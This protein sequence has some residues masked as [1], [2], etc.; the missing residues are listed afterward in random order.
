MSKLWQ[1][2]L[3]IPT[4]VRLTA[5]AP[6]DPHTAWDRYWTGIRATGRA[7][8]VLW[9]SGS[10]LEHEQY[11]GI[12]LDG[13]DPELPVIDVGC[14]NGTHTR[15]LAGLFPRV[16]GLDVSEGAIARAEEEAKDVPNADFLVL[17]AAGDG[18]GELLLERLG[19]A[20]VFVRGVFHVLKSDRQAA[21]ATNLRTVT[22][23]RGRV[24]LAETNF[25]GSSL[26]YLTELGATHH[27]VPRPL[28]R[29]LEHLPR[30]G[31]F[32]ATERQT[33]FPA[34]EWQVLAD[35]PTTIEVVPMKSTDLQQIPGYYAL[36]AGV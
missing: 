29:A 33:I 24:F 4:V 11:A 25:P 26:D 22:A 28:K 14:G 2:L 20:N 32:G 36:L 21:L 23:G 3:M 27:D 35:G 5:K 1:Q 6:R 12:I 31:R 34:S 19:P 9:D 18:A 16:L 8:D 10:A 30:P 13:F 15:W 7:G 17:D